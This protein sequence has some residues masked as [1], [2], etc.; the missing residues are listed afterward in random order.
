MAVSDKV[1][2]ELVD[3]T[4]IYKIGEQFVHAVDDVTLQVHGGETIAIMGPSGSGK[5]T[6]LNLIGCMDKPSSGK[7]FVEGRDTSKLSSDELADMR[8]KRIGMVFQFFNLIPVLTA[9]ENVEMPMV[10]AGVGDRQTRR[11][12][13]LEALEMVGIAK[14]ADRFPGQLSGGERQR[15]AI[16]RAIVN[17]PPILI[18]DEP[19]GNLDSETG[20]MVLEVL[21]SISGEQRAILI[22]THDQ[23]VVNYVGRLIRIK[24]GR[25]VE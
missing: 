15:V 18:A 13:A 7:V 12:T 6:L 16:A 21:T 9:L 23:D 17:H 8:A 4:K 25:L 19:T 3:A 14:K 1:V 24:D 20:K 11:K 2:V 22:A 10:Y 5:S